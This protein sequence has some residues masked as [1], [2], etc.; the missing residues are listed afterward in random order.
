MEGFLYLGVGSGRARA[1]GPHA[2]GRTFVTIL[3]RRLRRR[4]GRTSYRAAADEKDRSTRW[5]VP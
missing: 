5:D 1:E 4:G 3:G 2:H